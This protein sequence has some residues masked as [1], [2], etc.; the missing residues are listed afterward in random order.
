MKAKRKLAAKI[1]K[2]SPKKVSFAVEA[3]DEI[4]K[5]I[6]RS[7]IRGLINTTTMSKFEYVADLM[8]RR[9]TG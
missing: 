2:I 4:K 3:L 1:L 6:T 5:A 9:R 8:S 7:D